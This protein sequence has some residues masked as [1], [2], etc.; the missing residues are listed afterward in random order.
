MASCSS[1]IT[2]SYFRQQLPYVS[3]PVV[4]ERSEDEERMLEYLDQP[5]EFTQAVR[6]L[7]RRRPIEM[8]A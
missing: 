3:A 1:F 7:K 6:N 5:E 8:A 2:D 4:F